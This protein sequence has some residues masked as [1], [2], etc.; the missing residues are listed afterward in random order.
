MTPSE[1]GKGTDRRPRH[2]SGEVWDD[3]YEHAFKRGKQN[4]EKMRYTRKQQKERRDTG[5]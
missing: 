5:N 2:V 3:N 4:T 1:A